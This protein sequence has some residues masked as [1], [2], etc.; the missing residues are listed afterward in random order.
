[1]SIMKMLLTLTA[2][3]LLLSGCVSSDSGSDELSVD[4][5]AHPECAKQFGQP[6]DGVSRDIGGQHACF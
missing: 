3:A 6:A 2:A 4:S 5:N 1:M